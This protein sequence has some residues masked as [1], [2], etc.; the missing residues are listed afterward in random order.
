MTL[1]S[2]LTL[3]F[4]TALAVVVG[5][6][7]LVVIQAQQ[8]INNRQQDAAEDQQVSDSSPGDDADD[9]S[10]LKVPLVPPPHGDSDLSQLD[11]MAVP[12]SAKSVGNA[13]KAR[14]LAATDDDSLDFDND[15]FSLE[16]PAKGPTRPA[17]PRPRP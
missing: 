15:S 8:G 11:E 1:T 12:A 16:A 7:I 13:S 3:F 4:L 6:G 14:T 17:S 9:S 2:R 5:I 10:P